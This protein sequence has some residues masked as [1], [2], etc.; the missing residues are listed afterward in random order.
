MYVL[1]GNAGILGGLGQNLYERL[2]R[3]VVP[4]LDHRTA[5]LVQILC[6]MVAH[7]S[8]YDCIRSHF[9]GKLAKVAEG[10]AQKRYGR[11][12]PAWIAPYARRASKRTC[13]CLSQIFERHAITWT[14]RAEPMMRRIVAFERADGGE[15]N[16]GR[17]AFSSGYRPVQVGVHR[18]DGYVVANGSIDNR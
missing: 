11:N 12:S 9:T 13:A 2:F 10:P 8:A 16:E 14:E 7:F 3:A 17:Q 4:K 5:A 6:S 1:L 18:D 15:S